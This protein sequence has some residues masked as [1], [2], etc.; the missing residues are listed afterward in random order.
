MMEGNGGGQSVAFVHNEQSMTLSAEDSEKR[1]NLQREQLSRRPSYR[2]I[3]DELSEGVSK[4]LQKDAQQSSQPSIITVSNGEHQTLTPVIVSTADVMSA[5]ASTLT[6]SNNSPSVVLQSSQSQVN[7]VSHSDQ[8]LPTAIMSFTGQHSEHLQGL[9][10][11][12]LN[13]VV[14]SSPS[15]GRTT[16]ITAPYSYQIHRPQG[17]PVVMTQ[18]MP[19]NQQSPQ[20]LA[21]E[22]TRK[23]EIRL[24]KNREAARH[25]RV[26]KKEYLKCLEE[27]VQILEGQ[28]KKLIDELKALKEY[29]VLKKSD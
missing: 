26:K 21:D 6:N 3:L 5:L 29:Y 22:A 13:N 19:S 15:L 17:T 24:L 9:S 18:A 10:A 1:M 20:Q 14:Q 2:K 11:Q 7:N 25:C 27:R 16:L 12:V 28:N 4:D 23:R 8:Q